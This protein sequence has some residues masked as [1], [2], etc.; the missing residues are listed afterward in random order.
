VDRGQ[1]T[2]LPECLGNWDL[3]QPG[4]ADRQTAAGEA[5]SEE[6]ADRTTRLKE[7]RARTK[8]R[9]LCVLATR[10]LNNRSAR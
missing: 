7:K 4:T 6:L 8:M 10:R 2:L 1:T 9:M 5:P 3:S